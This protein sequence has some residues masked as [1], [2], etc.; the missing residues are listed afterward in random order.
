MTD[1]AEF[2]F[3]A[4]FFYTVVFREDADTPC[5][6]TKEMQS[7]YMF[8]STPAIMANLKIVEKRT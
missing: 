8:I 7:P 2:S 6:F 4:R 3:V 5:C 1:I